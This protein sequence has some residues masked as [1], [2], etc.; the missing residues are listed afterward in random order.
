MNAGQLYKNTGTLIAV[1]QLLWEVKMEQVLSMIE[2]GKQLGKRFSY[3]KK[4]IKF[5][6]PQ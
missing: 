3:T 6:G 1:L 5:I 2:L 4:I